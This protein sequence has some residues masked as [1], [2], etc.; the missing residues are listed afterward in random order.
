MTSVAP[1]LMNSAAPARMEDPP[2]ITVHGDNHDMEIEDLC[3][4]NDCVV[5]PIM[6]YPIMLNPLFPT[7]HSEVEPEA[8][9]PYL[10]GD[11]WAEFAVTINKELRAAQWAMNL[12]STIALTMVLAII[13][14]PKGMMPSLEIIICWVLL[15]G[16]L[17]IASYHAAKLYLKAKIKSICRAFSAHCMQDSR[18][19]FWVVKEQPKRQ[20]AYYVT[21][22]TAGFTIEA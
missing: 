4:D 14:V 1:A 10:S 13:I 18:L 2:T 7:H 3:G 16:I 20:T 5:T 6:K 11:K 21:L 15:G 8:L 12:M 9:R 17:L 19:I 22:V